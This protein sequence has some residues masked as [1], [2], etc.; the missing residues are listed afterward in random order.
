LRSSAVNK[1]RSCLCRQPLD[2]DVSCARED[3][4][5]LSPQ[6]L[7]ARGID[8]RVRFEHRLMSPL[9]SSRCSASPNPP[10]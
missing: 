3:P 8:Q 7:A 5:G 1:C 9:L 10:P 4:K 6:R 2:A